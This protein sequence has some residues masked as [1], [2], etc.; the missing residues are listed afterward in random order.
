MTIEK[1]EKKNSTSTAEKKIEDLSWTS[2]QFTCT[3]VSPS[4]FFDAS[5]KLE[6]KTFQQCSCKALAV[7]GVFTC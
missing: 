3:W 1:L 7:N 6:A 4:R 5:P 2:I